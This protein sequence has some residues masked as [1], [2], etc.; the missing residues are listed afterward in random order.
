MANDMKITF[1]GAAGEVT[2]SRHLLTACGQR[3]LMDCGMFQGHREE[4]LDK[5]R[6]FPFK[7]SGLDAA[8]L[9]HAHIDHIGGLPLLA[10]KGL[11]APIYCTGI[12]RELAGIMLMDSARL[13][14]AD[15]KFFNKIHAAEGRRI[16]PLYNEEDAKLALSRLKPCGYGTSGEI[17]PGISLCFLNAGHVLG[18]AMVQLD[19]K[20]N[21]SV[22]RLLYTGDLGRRSTIMMEVPKPPADVDYLIIE[23]TYGN[24]LHD[25]VNNAEAKLREIIA[26]AI[27][28][29]GKIIIPSFALERT[30]EIIFILD[31]LFRSEPGLNIPVYVDS[32]MAI[33]ITEIFNRHKD[34]F[35]FDPKFKE[36]AKM[37][38]DPFG[39]DYISYT[40]AKEQSQKLNEIDGPMIIISASGMCEGGRVLHHLRNNIDKDSTTILLVGYQAGGTLG[41][42]LQEGSPKVK[43]FGLQ[44]E[45]AARVETMHT[46]SSHADKDDLLAFIKGLSRPPRK[47]FLVHGDPRDRAAFAEHLKAEGITNTV[48]PEFGQEFDLD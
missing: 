24:R 2:G 23:T 19:I 36:Y 20:T 12:T 25:A 41:R 11:D 9:S 15:A 10:K 44:H 34:G 46:F 35:Y 29:R 38:G 16:E 3:I 5:N 26:R 18:S 4:S 8:I 13:Q 48:S 14:E 45:V 22:R 30:Q 37:D 40:R 42:R 31:K 17:G 32:P 39:Y 28:E 7:P 21:G 27:E 33:S 47:I 1:Y 6:K 43:I